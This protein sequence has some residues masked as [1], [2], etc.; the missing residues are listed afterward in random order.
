[1]ANEVQRV[2]RLLNLLREQGPTKVET[3][4]AQLD[5]TRTEL[6][7]LVEIASLCGRAPFGPMD[8]VDVYVDEDDRIHLEFDQ[9]LSK[10]LRLTE[11]EALAVLVTL[12]DA[13]AEAARS[14][15]QKIEAALS[16]GARPKV[17]ALMAQWAI[18]AD[19]SE[20]YW[21]IEQGFREQRK[22]EIEYYT[23]RRD[24]MTTR[25]LAVYQLSYHWGC[26]YA[27]GHD[28]FRDDVRI[29]KVERVR[30]ARLTDASYEPPSRFSGWPATGTG[31]YRAT[32]RVERKGRARL[33]ELRLA[34][35]IEQTEAHRTVRFPYPNI[36]IAL[37]LILSF[38]MG[39]EVLEPPELRDALR[40]R[41]SKIASLYRAG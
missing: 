16:A 37:S 20:V 23:A 1:M 22:V 33:E 27:V 39:A 18:D 40:D 19:F 24:Q 38:A 21:T 30:A 7:R 32:I 17:S 34:E 26:A 3:L 28:S 31:R 12:R 41:L 8:L 5:L 9:D 29:F 10:P 13:E 4:A 14:A 25:T 11:A 15:A 2:L 6:L 35:L 36:E